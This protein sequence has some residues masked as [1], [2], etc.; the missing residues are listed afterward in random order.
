MAAENDMLVELFYTRLCK[1]DE[2]REFI[3]KQTNLTLKEILSKAL[4]TLM[5]RFI[6]VIHGHESPTELP[7]QPFDALFYLQCIKILFG[8]PEAMKRLLE[9]GPE[10][11][12]EYFISWF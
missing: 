12:D 1:L 11:T 4:G 5:M 9:V 8:R 2:A 7:D 3:E 10:D 6:L